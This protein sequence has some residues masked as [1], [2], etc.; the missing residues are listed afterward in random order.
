[1]KIEDARWSPW[2]LGF[3]KTK[4]KDSGC[5]MAQYTVSS[6]YGHRAEETC[7]VCICIV[8]AIERRDG[9]C[10]VGIKK[11]HA[12][13]IAAQGLVNNRSRSLIGAGPS[14]GCDQA[15]FVRR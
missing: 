14:A 12:I 3:K 13:G 4:Q 7:P 6:V 8:E 9:T 5:R 15:T 10:G 1:M 11:Q 2:Q